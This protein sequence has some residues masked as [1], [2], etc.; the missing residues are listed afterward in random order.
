MMKDQQKLC[1]TK[2]DGTGGKRST[3]EKMENT[4]L[5]F[6]QMDRYGEEGGRE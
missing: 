6:N 2:V 5:Y 4:V 1:N 3:E